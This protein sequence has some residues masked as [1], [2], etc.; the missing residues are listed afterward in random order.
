MAT[1]KILLNIKFIEPSRYEEMKQNRKIKLYPLNNN[2]HNTLPPLA[3]N[4]KN[5]LRFLKIKP[6]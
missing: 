4:V 2:I 1:N 3:Q 5:H 6:K